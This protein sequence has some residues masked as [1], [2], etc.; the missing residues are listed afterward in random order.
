MAAKKIGKKKPTRSRAI[1]IRVDEELAAIE[2]S[3]KTPKK[4]PKPSREKVKPEIQ[5]PKE[6]APKR[7]HKRK[8]P[9]PE[10]EKPKAK[11]KKPKLEPE[12]EKEPTRHKRKKPKPE[13]PK[14]EKPKPEKPKPEKPKP[15]KKRKRKVP[16]IRSRRRKY[17]DPGPLD[18]F[19]IR[20]WDDRLYFELRERAWEVMQGPSRT[21]ELDMMN[22][23]RAFGV[24]LRELYRL[25]FS[26]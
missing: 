23:A 16:G 11:R 25:Y 21:R 19:N 6:E 3:D 26:P 5:A 18:E 1:F 10:P 17:R 14:P 4:K 9:K 20:T 12:P 13:K 8:K 15:K 22:L 2:V 24:S 7:S